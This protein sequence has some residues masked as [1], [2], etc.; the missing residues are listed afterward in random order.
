MLKEEIIKSSNSKRWF[1]NSYNHDNN[2]VFDK[3]IDTI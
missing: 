3:L 1:K 2:T